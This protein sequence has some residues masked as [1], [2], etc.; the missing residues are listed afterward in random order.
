MSDTNTPT[1]L[2]A[3][4]P[5]P[6]LGRALITTFG[7][8]H[9]RPASGTW[10][11]MPPAVM[12]GA[13]AINGQIGTPMAYAALVVLMVLF[14]LACLRFGHQAEATFGKKDPGQVVADETAGMALTLLA[15]PVWW[16]SDPSRLL[17][18]IAGAFVLFRL[19]DI[20]KLPPAHG[21]Q[22]LPGG[23]GILIDDLIAGIHAALVL[24]AVAFFVR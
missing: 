6:A 1:A 5:M 3:S 12:A 2:T 8:G 24:V 13:M 10:G 19:F 16:T 18:Y 14:S 11:S 4:A 23:A 9:M 15:L 20:L 17:A 22:R 7:L 21:L